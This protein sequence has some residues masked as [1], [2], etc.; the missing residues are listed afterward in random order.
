[1]GCLTKTG[2]DQRLKLTPQIHILFYKIFFDKTR[3][4]PFHANLCG[5]NPV[6]VPQ[7]ITIF[8]ISSFQNVVLKVSPLPAERGRGGRNGADTLYMLQMAKH[9][10]FYTPSVF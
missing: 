3:S 1:M 5:S 7:G 10:S 4:K 6:E 2:Q 8:P 9:Y